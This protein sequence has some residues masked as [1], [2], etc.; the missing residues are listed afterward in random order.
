M[1]LQKIWV[2]TL[3]FVLF[4]LLVPSRSFSQDSTNYQGALE[5]FYNECS[6]LIY[7]KY[8]EKGY[9]TIF[10]GKII[11]KTEYDLALLYNDSIINRLERLNKEK[12][13][14]TFKIAEEGEDEIQRIKE[15]F[16]RLRG[17]EKSANPVDDIE[18]VVIA[19]ITLDEVRIKGKDFFLSLNLFLTTGDNWA[20][21]FKLALDYRGRD[22]AI[23]NY[24]IKKYYSPF[25]IFSFI[26]F[27]LFIILA[28]IFVYKL[29]QYGAIKEVNISFF[30]M[31]TLIYLIAI[32]VF[33][34]L[35]YL[36]HNLLSDT[37]FFKGAEVH[38]FMDTN[39][40]LYFKPKDK[41][42]L[43]FTKTSALLAK[44][45]FDNIST[46]LYMGR[47]LSEKLSDSIFSF[48]NRIFDTFGFEQLRIGEFVAL[49]KSDYFYKFHTFT[50]DEDRGSDE[51]RPLSEGRFGEIEHDFNENL[52]HIRRIHAQNTGQSSLIK[53]LLQLI[54]LLDEKKGSEDQWGKM[55]RFI[56]IL[57]DAD[58]GYEENVK[59]LLKHIRYFYKKKDQYLRVFSILFP[60]LPK[61]ED[62]IYYYE[63]G[64]LVLLSKISEMIVNLNANKSFNVE[65]FKDENERYYQSLKLSTDDQLE[66]KYFKK[67][68]ELDM[69]VKNNK[70]LSIEE[71]AGKRILM[72]Y[73]RNKERQY[74]QMIKGAGEE[75][76]TSNSI[77]YQDFFIYTFVNN[78]YCLDHIEKSMS[79]KCINQDDDCQCSGREF[80]QKKRWMENEDIKLD[81]NTTRTKYFSLPK[82]KNNIKDL[83]LISDVF[84]NQFIFIGFD[85]ER[86]ASAINN[87]LPI[88]TILLGLVFAWFLYRYRY[89]VNYKFSRQKIIVDSIVIGS[90]MIVQLSLFF[91]IQYTKYRWVIYGDFL[92]AFF[93]AQGFALCVYI[94]PQAINLV[95]LKKVSLDRDVLF[96][97]EQPL[98][99]R[100]VDRYL[101]DFILLPIM[102]ISI[103][104]IIGFPVLK[105]TFSM[106]AGFLGYWTNLLFSDYNNI[107]DVFFIVWCIIGLLFILRSLIYSNRLEKHFRFN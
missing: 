94:I 59:E 75:T 82:N 70:I 22:A 26:G 27:T 67:L 88:L 51:L 6:R 78:M 64:K 21:P 106:S 31:G 19:E 23:S 65:K 12:E 61:S 4:L 76:K 96:H 60:N 80:M 86:L 20:E 79:S 7:E 97:F 101:F 92:Q 47:S 9:E 1:I 30:Y 98:W 11:N 36:K 29:K 85:K 104:L 100:R 28:L 13:R 15:S 77:E 16:K 73:I 10:W 34:D 37:A 54:K 8:I 105:E 46:N 53:P 35:T 48:L 42:E 93:V 43:N 33:I 38:F 3:G 66:Q 5:K 91:C 99:L 89:H 14:R 41:N 40:G 90:M 87:W 103:F 84:V 2:K 95:L 44:N 25:I 107:I 45:I 57:T 72:D 56:I 17:K 50:F 83:R 49:K 52:E 68:N 71:I 24:I 81:Y 69:L 63:N 102:T 39:A 18:K 58:E 32:M 55:K 74:I 62:K